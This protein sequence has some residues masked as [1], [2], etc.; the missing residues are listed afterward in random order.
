MNQDYS[1][2]VSLGEAMD[3]LTILDI[4]LDKIK[5]S[6]RLEVKKEYDAIYGVLKEPCHLYRDLYQSMKKINQIIW[7]LMDV[8]RD[9]QST[10]TEYLEACKKCI[11]YNDIRFRIKN[12]INCT[13]NSNLKEQKGYNQTKIRIYFHEPFIQESRMKCIRYFSYL[14]D[15]VLISP[16]ETLE[17]YFESDPTILFDDTSE[18]IDTFSFTNSV[19]TKSGTRIA[20]NSTEDELFRI[21]F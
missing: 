16:N 14:Y 9:G 19:W 15:L 21:L 5:D 13:S 12:K 4:K 8:I 10:D 1:L 2:N 11:E 7:D 3:K 18:S 20:F 17:E 6:R